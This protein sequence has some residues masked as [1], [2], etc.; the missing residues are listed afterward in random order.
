MAHFL[1]ILQFLYET[2]TLFLEKVGVKFHRFFCRCSY[3][4]AV[5]AINLHA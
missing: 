5:C 3:V 4:I 2:F 1:N